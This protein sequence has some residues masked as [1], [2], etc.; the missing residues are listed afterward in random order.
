VLD[1]ALDFSRWWEK[2]VEA[3]VAKDINH[4]SVIFCSIGNEIPESATPHRSVWGRRIAEKFRSLD[5][6]RFLSNATNATLAIT[7][8]AV[9]VARRRISESA[10]TMGL[11]T[12]MATMGEVLDEL[13]T[14]DLETEQTTEILSTLDVVGYN[15]LEGRYEL[16][17]KLFPHRVIMGSE[18]HPTLIDRLWR[19]VLDNSHVIGDFTWTGSAD[20]TGLAFADI[21]LTER[22]RNLRCRADRP[23]TVE[24]TGPGVLQGLGSGR[25]ATEETFA[26][27][28][29]TP[30]TTAGHSPSY[31]PPEPARPQ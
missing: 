1:Y 12:M 8:E 31:G 18:T 22:D 27:C 11:K 21:V 19:L 17:R 25:P 4:P 23:V 28:T 16:D 30:R 14:S 29:H 6:T 5:E 20:D 26:G 24:N 13:S 7:D 10:E 2:D 9:A 3:L 15:Y